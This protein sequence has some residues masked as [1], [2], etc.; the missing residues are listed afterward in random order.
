LEWLAGHLIQ[1]W[2]LFCGK[3]WTL[4][5]KKMRVEIQAS[6]LPLGEPVGVSRYW[7]DVER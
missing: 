4:E 7:Y 6:K 5:K 3:R 1:R 2:L